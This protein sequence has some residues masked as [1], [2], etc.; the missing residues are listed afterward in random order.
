MYTV[1][2]LLGQ[3]LYSSALLQDGGE[4]GWQTKAEG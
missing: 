4:S 1:M 2:L 3:Y